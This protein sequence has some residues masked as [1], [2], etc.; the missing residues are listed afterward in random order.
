[1]KLSFC[2]HIP[3]LNNHQT[4]NNRIFIHF[5]GIVSFCRMYLRRP[6]YKEKMNIHVQKCFN[7]LV[8]KLQNALQQTK[9]LNTAQ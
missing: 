5:F 6:D 2:F 9:R 4:M 3:K 8:L 7:Y 1:M